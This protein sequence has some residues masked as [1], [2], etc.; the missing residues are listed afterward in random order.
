MNAPEI[1]I[2][3][4]E[5]AKSVQSRVDKSIVLLVINEM[6]A[7]DL[8]NPLNIVDDADIPKDFSD[9]NKAYIRLAI[10]GYKD[11]AP[12]KVI[13][14]CTNI[15]PTV[16]NEELEIMSVEEILNLAK[17]DNYNLSNFNKSSDKNTVI[18]EFLS[19]QTAAQKEAATNFDKA[20]K[21]I[22]KMKFAYMAYPDTTEENYTKIKDWIIEQRNAGNKVKAVLPNVEGDSEGII[23]YINNKNVVVESV[24][25]GADWENIQ[26]EYTAAQF[27]PRIA[28]LLA[29]LP[30]GYSATYAE[31]EEVVDCD[32]IEDR[33]DAVD[34]G[35]F[36]IFNDGS[37][38]KTC[39]AVNSLQSVP[40][41]KNEDFKKIRIV[42]IMDT[43]NSDIALLIEDE[44]IGKYPNTYDNKCILI[45]AID[46][47]LKEL[48]SMGMLQS[49]SVEIDIAAQ[50][51]YLKEKGY[52]ASE[53]SDDEIKQA[54]TGTR[55]FITGTVAILDAIEDISWNIYI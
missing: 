51:N 8:K 28:G 53:M 50:K 19:Q 11:D 9:T 32:E 46:E 49:H 23:N 2:K 31:L 13:V 17:K 38:F 52:D 44:Y 6:I 4:V 22:S 47:Y 45:S 37:K 36:F 18:N 10:K 24:K 48:E 25:T 40:E 3:F 7:A 42:H 41:E 39:R 35:K 1:N 16:T 55:V 14:Y 33:N 12:K 15:A 21:A 54:M 43:I 5:T 26:T 34:K 29:A 20:L 27:T 30:S